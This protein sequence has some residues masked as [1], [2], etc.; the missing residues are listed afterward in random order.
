MDLYNEITDM[1]LAFKVPPEI[2]GFDY[3]REGIFLCYHDS[4]LKN[5]IT[6]QLYPQIAK[7]FSTTAETVERG[8]RTAV[9][10]SY[11]SG[12]LLEVNEKCGM[13]VYKN[14]FKRTNGE[15]MTT[16]VAL[17]KLKETRQQI[18]VKLQKMA[19]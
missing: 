14:D 6:K 4:S 10:N 17:I 1:L 7:K 15:M 8:M 12:G 9:E 18:E 3:L 13:V 19:Q 5:N 11:N 16:I 2:M